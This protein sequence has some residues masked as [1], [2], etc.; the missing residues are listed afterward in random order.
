[1]IGE[2]VWDLSKGNSCRVLVAQIGARRHYAVPR[3]LYYG[4]VLERLVTDACAEVPPWKWLEKIVP[5][6]VRPLSLRRLVVRRVSDIPVGYIR[7]FPWFALSASWDRK[8]GEPQTDYWARRNARFG[9]LVVKAGFGSAN[10]VYAFNGAALEIFQAAKEKGLRTI[11]DQTAAPWRWNARLLREEVSRWPGWEDRPAEIDESGLLS[12]REETEWKLANRIIC[13][14]EFAKEALID[15]GG[16]KGLCDVVPYPAPIIEEMNFSSN[17]RKV[18]NHEPFKVL[19]VGTLQLRK[20]VQYLLKAKKLLR[21]KKI[22]FRLVGPSLLSQS[23]MN[24]LRA[25]LDVVGSVP[26]T[27]VAK[28][29]AWA[30]VFVLP[31]LSEGSANVVY[32]AMAAGLPVIT[33]PNAGSSVRN[34]ENGLIVPVR[35]AEALAD[36][37][38]MLSC[39]E[40]TRLQYILKAKK[41]NK[42]NSIKT[43]SKM[44]MRILLL[45]NKI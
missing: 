1:M 16:P 39:K 31:T 29:Y 21:H 10:T 5:A 9:R 28:H 43:Y 20:G 37:I 22:E 25:E 3:A 42:S 32:E 18:N 36:A 19:F 17:S 26:R 30:D 14:S 13:G 15:C 44:L 2:G 27:E 40:P 23:A 7:G 4:G 33:T 11:L 45:E 8:H 6:T 12:D 35:D 38:I 34:G 41:I 24:E